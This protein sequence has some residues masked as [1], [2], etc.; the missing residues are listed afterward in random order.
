M[1]MSTD[2]RT[3]NLLTLSA[4]PLSTSRVTV[5]RKQENVEVG[6]TITIR[7]AK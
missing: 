7:R 3:V 2:R 6:D 4:S 5:R 1:S